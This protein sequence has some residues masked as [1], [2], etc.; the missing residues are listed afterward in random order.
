[1]ELHYFPP[2]DAARR[3]VL[4]AESKAKLHAGKTLVLAVLAG[5]FLALAAA[6]SNAAQLAGAPRFVGGALFTGGLFMILLS[7]AELF[8]GNM[9]MSAAYLCQR[10][11]IFSLLKNWILVYI[12]NAGGAVAVSL[13]LF[14]VTPYTR[15]FTES[16][17]YLSGIVSAKAGM[18]LRDAFLLGILCNVLVCMAVYTS[19]AAKDVAGKLLA[20]FFPIWLFVTS[21]YEHCVANMFYLWPALQSGKL[22]QLLLHNLL[23]VTAG[24][25]VGGITLAC[26]F[27]FVFIRNT[28]KP[29]T[30]TEN[31]K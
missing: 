9:L 20:A 1:M 22:P 11:T 24:N 15:G 25:A 5:A 27:Y 8:T 17:E 21:G 23:P 4:S 29:Q 26:A 30:E 14:S 16:A 2:K 12:G 28:N 10:V 7:G 19:Y 13:L 31:S 18:P 3:C 6:G